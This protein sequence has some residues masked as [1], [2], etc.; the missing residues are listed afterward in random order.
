MKIGMIVAM[1]REIESAMAAFGTPVR[2]E[3]VT[4]IDV[5]VYKI[6]E[7]EVYLTRSGAGEIYA[8][9][10]AQTLITKYGVQAIINY[11]IV[12]GLTEEMSLC[13]TAVVEKVVHYDFDASAIDG[14]EPARYISYPSVFLETDK[15][16]LERACG[17]VPGLKRVVCASGDKFVADPEKKRELHEKF[18]ADI[19]EMEAAGILLTADR[20]GVPVLMIK[21]VSDSLFGGAE[22]AEKS[23]EQAA[24]ECVKALMAVLYSA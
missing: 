3:T 4:G 22:E 10:A 7:H 15:A 8:A 1:E 6:G 14:C 20:A 12:G 23:V 21:S 9:G 2:R 18:G 17:A 24:G 11:G 13:R 16:L 5:S 19:C